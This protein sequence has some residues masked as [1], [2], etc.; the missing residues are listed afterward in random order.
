MNDNVKK[1]LIGRKT[2]VS[3]CGEPPKSNPNEIVGTETI[4]HVSENELGNYDRIIGEASI[5]YIGSPIDE[6][7]RLILETMQKV[8][9]DKKQEIIDVCQ[10]ILNAK[11]NDEKFK[12][13]GQLISIGANIAQI[14]S[15]IV[16]LEQMIPR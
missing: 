1:I 8:D 6:H 5:L 7:V 16:Q 12:W 11:Q 4:V 14:A 15:F 2:V 9:S 10:K 13:V 3:I